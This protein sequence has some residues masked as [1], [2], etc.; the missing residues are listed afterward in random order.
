MS[1]NLWL[2]SVAAVLSVST[3]SVH[4]DPHDYFDIPDPG[5]QNYLRSMEGAHVAT[6]PGW[7]KDRK[8]VV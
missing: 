1:R 8:S 3:A 5:T 7:I 4:A 6:I 2:L